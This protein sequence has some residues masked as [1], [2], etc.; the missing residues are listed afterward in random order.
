MVVNGGLTSHRG[1]PPAITGSRTTTIVPARAQQIGAF[2]W[3]FARG[4]TGL[5]ANAVSRPP[6]IYMVDT[7]GGDGHTS[8]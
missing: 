4:G 3:R 5:R 8:T 6:W 1:L 2:R 7:G